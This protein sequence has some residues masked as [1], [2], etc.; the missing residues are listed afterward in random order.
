MSKILLRQSLSHNTPANGAMLVHNV[1]EGMW[2]VGLN[3][4]DGNQF[5]RRAVGLGKYQPSPATFQGL[6]AECCCNSSVQAN[7]SAVD[8]QRH[9]RDRKNAHVI[10]ANVEFHDVAATVWCH[11][12]N[13]RTNTQL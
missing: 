11:Q 6:E 12:H 5:A 13:V 4:H 9:Q 3:K 8:Y 1:T 2:G 7:L 10:G